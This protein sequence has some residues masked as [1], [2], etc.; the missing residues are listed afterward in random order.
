VAL[1]CGQNEAVSDLLHWL[2][3]A[4]SK[5]AKETTQARDGM[6]MLRLLIKDITV[7]KQHGARRAFLRPSSSVRRPANP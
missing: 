3:T 2:N 7:E 1:V 6:R 5:A 4:L